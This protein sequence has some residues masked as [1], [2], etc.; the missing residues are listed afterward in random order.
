MIPMNLLADLHAESLKCQKGAKSFCRQA[1]THS[2]VAIVA[3]AG[4][5]YVVSGFTND[6]NELY[7][8]IDAI[9]V[10]SLPED[11]VWDECAG[12][13][14]PALQ[15]ADRLLSQIADDSIKNVVVF[16][17]GITNPKHSTK[18]A[19]Y[20]GRADNWWFIGHMMEINLYEGANSVYEQAKI[21]QGKYNV[22]SIGI[23]QNYKSAPSSM[24]NAIE[25]LRDTVRD[26]ASSRDQFYD[27]D[28][29]EQLEFIFGGVAEDI[30]APQEK[31]IIFIPGVMGSR[32][33]DNNL[34]L[35]PPASVKAAGSLG[36]RILS[37]ELRI[38]DAIEDQRPLPAHEKGGSA[39]L[40]A[41]EY[42]AQDTYK[43]M[44]DPC[45]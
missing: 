1:A 32:L 31:P 22:Y 35:W 36:N 37:N 40:T 21:L 12:N 11:N 42:G 41:R 33:F 45:C 38:R 25:L 9:T 20:R 10:P 8:K 44:I 17:S 4:E 16:S 14:V 7:A 39:P 5:S 34:Q 2:K 3:Y 13:I 27:V 28:D 43:E 24:S 26:I 30:A 23:F 18:P 6:L 19:R 29:I 15:E